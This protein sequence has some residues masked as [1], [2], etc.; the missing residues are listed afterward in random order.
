MEEEGVESL[1][2]ERIKGQEIFLSY[3]YHKVQD[4]FYNY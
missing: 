1:N 2:R 3:Q 4:I